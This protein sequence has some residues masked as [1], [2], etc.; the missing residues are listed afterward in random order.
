M[1]ILY[2]GD[3][4]MFSG[5]IISL[6]SLTKHAKEPLNIYILT[7]KLHNRHHQF[8]ALSDDHAAF[9]DQLVKRNGEDNQVTK[10]DMTAQFEADPPT[11]NINTLF[12]PYSMLRLY[13]DLVP[14][15]SDRILYLD[16]DVVCRRPF[17]DF[18]HQ[19]L[20]DTDF[21]G[22][23]DHYGRWFFHHQLKPFDYI[24]SGMLLMNLKMIR[25]DKLLVRCRDYCRKWPMIMP[26]QSAMNKLAKHKVFA[27]EKYNEQQDVQADTVFQHFSTRWKLWPIIHTVSVKPWEVDKVHEQLH[28]HE[29]DDILMA[30][31]AIVTQLGAQGE[32]NLE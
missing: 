20:A 26:D 16:A 29:Y 19:S 5:L 13:S 28:L 1:D 4:H 15:F 31:Q 32:L 21:V 11:A 14:Q 7:G 17:E 27:P 12:T 24:N 9:L 25:Q 10:L 18:Y 3:D 2:C 8:Q 6:L 23:L 22:V 30:Y